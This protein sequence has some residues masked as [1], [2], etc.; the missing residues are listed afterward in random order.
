MR[1]RN[2]MTDKF[3]PKQRAEIMRRIAGKN[4]APE[5]QVRSLLHGLGYRFRIHRRDLPGRPDIVLS[6]YRAVILVHGCFW[7]GHKGCRRA[8]IPQTRTE[9][10]RAKIEKNM[11]RD[12]VVRGKLSKLGY[13]TIV[14]W[15][16]ELRNRSAVASRLDKRLQRFGSS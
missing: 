4:T 5:L 14:V 8:T 2:C 11:A 15:Q 13:R 3:T 10:W 12:V 7:H 9:F 6:R 1:Q 16:C